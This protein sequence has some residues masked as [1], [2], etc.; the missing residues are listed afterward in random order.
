MSKFENVSQLAMHRISHMA[1]GAPAALTMMRLNKRIR[2]Q[3]QGPVGDNHLKREFLSM[4]VG[5]DNVDEFMNGCTVR[6]L[7][8]VDPFTIEISASGGTS[9]EKINFI[10]DM[11]EKSV[12]N[13]CV[14]IVHPDGNRYPNRFLVMGTE[15]M[16]NYRLYLNEGRCVHATTRL[17]LLN[18]DRA[19]STAIDASKELPVYPQVIYIKR[20]AWTEPDMFTLGDEWFTDDVPMLTRIKDHMMLC[21][22]TPYARRIH[23]LDE[24]VDLLDAYVTDRLGTL[25]ALDE[26][27]LNDDFVQAF[28]ALIAEAIRSLDADHDYYAPVVTYTD[29]PRL[30]STWLEAKG[31]KGNHKSMIVEFNA[32]T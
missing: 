26:N 30:Y 3:L 13:G 18:V 5:K 24:M 4:V 15:P 12:S 32:I 14:S 25:P 29:G 28:T 9:N 22:A 1:G 17:D 7:R 21:M 8:E 19:W 6:V 27:K 2:E 16:R 31:Y 10:R 23:R 20:S 11:K